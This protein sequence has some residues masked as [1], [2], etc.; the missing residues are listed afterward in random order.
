M[1][2]TS[3]LPCLIPYV[4]LGAQH[5]SVRDELL[6]AVDRVL[7]H[8]Q[9]ILGDEVEAFEQEFAAYCGTRFAV[10]VGNGTD[11]IT[12]SLQAL[13]IGTGDEVI[14]A[15][16]SFVASAAAIAL[17]GAQPVFADVGDDYNL[18]PERVVAAITPR[19][20]AILPV[21]LTGRPADMDALLDIA[22]RR[23]LHLVE[24]AA[25]AVGAEYRDR[26]T[27]S[28]GV[29]G[30]F[31]L[32]PLK[33]LSACGDG[34]VVT[35]DDETLYHRL[36]QA[37]NHGLGDRNH[38]AFWSMNSRLDALQAALL[39]VKLKYLDGWTEARRANAAYYR[40]Q[41]QGAVWVPQDSPDELAVYH[42]FVIQSEYRDELREFLAARG[43]AT[44]VHYPVPIHL[45]EAAAD[46]GYTQGDFPVA[47]QQADRIL[48]L[49]IYPELGEEQRR[50][51]VA[52]IREFMEGDRLSGHDATRRS[53][54]ASP[55]LPGR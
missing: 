26:R 19:T 49:P 6:S 15:P 31:S 30:C 18:D 37:R 13:G 12:L 36:R 4:D 51:V 3:S 11:A 23:G 38:C 1:N 8:G 54:Q 27:G 45:Q 46:L 9:F 22:K 5:A 39:R 28:F 10:G 17:A 20:R 32:H 35:T 55:A 2:A 14:T 34:G 21:H 16:N 33:N 41:L 7:S 53:P 24:D 52:A 47:E 25:Q 48:S 40:S 42:T 44:A 43:I 50:R 29:A